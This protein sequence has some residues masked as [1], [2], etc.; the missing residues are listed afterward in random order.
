ML[1]LLEPAT[2]IPLELE[3]IEGVEVD[4]SFDAFETAGSEL[5]IETFLAGSGRKPLLWFDEFV[6]V[7]TA[8]SNDDVGETTRSIS[9]K[10]QRYFIFAIFSSKQFFSEQK[11]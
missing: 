3:I 10:S 9:M 1:P 11:R 4:K 5:I 7:D 8:V 6:V 2:D